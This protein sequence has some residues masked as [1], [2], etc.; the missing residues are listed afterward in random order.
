MNRRNIRN[1]QLES[2]GCRS[3]RKLH[4]SRECESFRFTASVS[5]EK[6]K[7]VSNTAIVGAKMALLSEKARRKANLISRK[8]RYLE[9][10]AYSIFKEE[11]LKS[12]FI[13]HK[14][15]NIFP[16]VQKVLEVLRSVQI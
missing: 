6:I 8:V 15:L 2:L 12:T 11:F 14:Y 9:L 5:T 3:L 4:Q 10:A 13:L 7:F 1:E 16:S